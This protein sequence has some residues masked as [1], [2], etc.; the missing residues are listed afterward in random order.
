MTNQPRDNSGRWT[1]GLLDSLKQQLAARGEENPHQKAIEI[2][3]EQGSVDHAGNLTRQGEAR[4]RLGR[5]GRAKDRAAR[6]LGR[7]PE[8]MKYNPRTRRTVIR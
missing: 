8:D 2:L 6:Q 3:R 4:Q 5:E 7:E 1:H